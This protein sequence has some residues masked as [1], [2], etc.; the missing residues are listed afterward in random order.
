MNFVLDCSVTMAWLFE[1]QAD[2]YTEAVLK[3]LEDQAA[4]VP[5]LWSYE[6]ANVLMVGERKKIVSVSQSTRFLELLH[7]LNIS[8]QPIHD[9]KHEEALLS[10]GRVF[11]LSSYDASYLALAMS[12]G[13][14]LATRDKALLQ[15]CSKAG[16]KVYK[17]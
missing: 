17:S 11:G 3:T 16:V 5:I 8:F 6:V 14:P 10:K 7:N 12:R 1:D 9:V 13:L 2:R 4:L 15:A